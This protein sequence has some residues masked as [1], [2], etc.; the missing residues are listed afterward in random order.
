MPRLR[1]SMGTQELE[2]EGPVEFIEQYDAPIANVLRRFASELPASGETPTAPELHTTEHEF[3]EALH[4]LPDDASGT[5]QILL[6]GRF[7]QRASDTNTFSTREANELLKEQDVKLSNAS[8][9]LKVNLKAK[10]VFKF[11]G[12]YRVSQVGER[13][14]DSLMEQSEENTK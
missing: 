13:H 3:G 9:F 4:T 12:G 7:A 10:R 11:E 1:V 8:Q 5:D 6:A 14:L 2:L